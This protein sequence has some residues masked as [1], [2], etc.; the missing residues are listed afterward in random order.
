MRGDGCVKCDQLLWSSSWNAHI[1]LTMMSYIAKLSRVTC[2]I[3]G[4]KSGEHKEI[5]YSVCFFFFM[6]RF[7]YLYFFK[8]NSWIAGL[9]LNL[10]VVLHGF[11]RFPLY[12]GEILPSNIQELYNSSSELRCVSH[13]P[14][15][16]NFKPHRGQTFSCQVG[17]EKKRSGSWWER[18]L[19]LFL[20]SF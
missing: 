13:I 18:Q 14:Y 4:H 20:L 9:G 16:R 6:V 7:L 19:L 2:Q 12:R 17:L 3:Y 10:R 11:T 5:A 8:R 15:P 1:Y